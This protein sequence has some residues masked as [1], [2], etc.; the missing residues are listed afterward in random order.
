MSSKGRAYDNLTNEEKI[1]ALILEELL[2]T[3]KQYLNQLEYTAEKMKKELEMCSNL[4]EFEIDDGQVRGLFGNIEALHS[5][6]K[7][8]YKRLRESLPEGRER[9]PRNSIGHCFVNMRTAFQVYDQYLSNH[10]RSQIVLSEISSM[11]SM[12][13]V[14][15]RWQKECPSSAM[16][17]KGK[18]V[19]EVYLREPL[20][21][22]CKYN[23]VLKVL[24]SFT[25]FHHPDLEDLLSAH[26]IIHALMTSY[27]SVTKMDLLTAAFESS[28]ASRVQW[29][30]TGLENKDGFLTKRGGNVKTWKIRWFTLRGYEL[31]YYDEPSN[32]RPLYTLDL[33]HCKSVVEDSSVGKPHCFGIQMPERTYQIY[34]ISEAEKIAW[35]NAIAWRLFH[36]LSVQMRAGQCM[37]ASALSSSTVSPILS[38]VQNN[39][40]SHASN[41][42]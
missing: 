2:D 40:P 35:M 7:E 6:H 26:Q 33:K 21:R 17:L 16:A 10:S 4:I 42:H 23:V 41:G 1:R 14:Y 22:I 11:S 9:E 34:C 27:D 38:L 39:S 12:Q 20:L 30:K 19:L 24:A 18:P 15:Q 37:S 32:D 29:E 5:V 3:E 31:K 8:F 25:S 13:G 28:D 36:N